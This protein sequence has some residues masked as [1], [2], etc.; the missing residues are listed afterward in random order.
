MTEIGLTQARVK[1]LLDYDPGTG[2]FIWRAIRGG[3]AGRTAGA[4]DTRGYRLIRV[5]YRLYRSCRLA[6]LYMTG[7]WPECQ[8]DHVNMV[9]DDDSW[10]NLRLATS[11]QNNMN[12]RARAGTA[13][14]L[15]GVSWD[16][17]SGKWVALITAFGV[18]TWLGV[19]DDPQEAHRAYSDAAEKFH[20]EYR[21]V[22]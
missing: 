18:T 7:G 22:A 6:W 19:F 11:S 20:G 4:L 14:G 13:S 3:P 9:R 1:E 8:I 10:A 17:R 5:D 16:S 15:K 12:R 2:V 21:R